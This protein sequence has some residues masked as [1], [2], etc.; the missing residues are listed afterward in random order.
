VTY[1]YRYPDGSDTLEILALDATIMNVESS[2]NRLDLPCL[3]LS[4]SERS[5]DEEQD[6]P[7]EH[8]SSRE[9]DWSCPVKLAG[10]QR[11][12]DGSQSR[13]QSSKW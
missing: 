4:C 7:E 2:I 3:L 1:V 10:E 5:S 13:Q 8:T 11:A 12:G 6:E 9:P